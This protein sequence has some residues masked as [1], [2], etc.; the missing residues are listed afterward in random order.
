MIFFFSGVFLRNIPCLRPR[1]S[2]AR[3]AFCRF[4]FDRSSKVSLS[5][6]PRSSLQRHSRQQDRLNRLDR[7]FVGSRNRGVVFRVPFPF[8][9]GRPSMR[10]PGFRRLTLR[11]GEDCLYI[12]LP[13]VTAIRT[14]PAP[15]LR[16]FSVVSSSRSA[17]QCIGFAGTLP[18]HVSPCPHFNWIKPFPASLLFR[19]F[20]KFHL[21]SRMVLIVWELCNH[22]TL[23]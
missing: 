6:P 22:P 8:S 2:H 3:K 20:G 17:S 16:F 12:R 4:I 5:F 7:G 11:E 1:L 19:M 21:S 18:L 14:P 13:G 15:L 23:A 10:N 9:H